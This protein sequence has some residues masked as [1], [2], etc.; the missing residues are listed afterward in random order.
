MKIGEEEKKNKLVTEE[1]RGEE[2]AENATS[3]LV[4]EYLYGREGNGNSNVCKDGRLAKAMKFNSM[5][6]VM[7]RFLCSLQNRPKLR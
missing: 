5:L 6:F 1:D 2:D 4:F 7:C 3:T